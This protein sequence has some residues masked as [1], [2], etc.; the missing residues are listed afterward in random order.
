VLP[1]ASSFACLVMLCCSGLRGL[2]G[3]ISDR[4]LFHV[5]VAITNSSGWNF[6]ISDTSKSGQKCT[7][8]KDVPNLFPAM[9]K[10]MNLVKAKTG[11]H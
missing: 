10:S 5:F 9:V 1:L 2:R 3:T 11:H 4:D 6:L 7:S 8:L